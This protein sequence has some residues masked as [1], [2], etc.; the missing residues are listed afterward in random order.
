MANPIRIKKEY[1][2]DYPIELV[3]NL[4]DSSI[5]ICKLI[6]DYKI[7]D[8]ND[9][10]YRGYVPDPFIHITSAENQI[11]ISPYWEEIPEEVDHIEF[12]TDETIGKKE[13]ISRDGEGEIDATDLP[14]VLNIHCQSIA[15]KESGCSN[16]SQITFESVNIS[17]DVNMWFPYDP[18]ERPDDVGNFNPKPTT[19]HFSEIYYN[20]NGAIEYDKN[21]PI[22]VLT[23]GINWDDES[24]GTLIRSCDKFE[25]YYKGKHY[26]AIYSG[27]KI[28]QEETKSE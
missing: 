26:K 2:P 27:N 11:L 16:S 4:K 19:S 9:K 1:L 5:D 12:W 23:K 25:L 6:V 17:V 15:T 7:V 21:T 8:E 10:E 28:N 22:M 13:T 3:K 18:G 14:K 24:Q 20:E